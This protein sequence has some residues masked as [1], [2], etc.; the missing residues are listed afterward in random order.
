MC[1]VF[2]EIMGEIHADPGRGKRPCWVQG[3]MGDQS[4]SMLTQGS[5]DTRDFDDGILPGPP[6][7]S[8]PVAPARLY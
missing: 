1:A 6:P 2:K 3:M 4:K 7:P 8:S 5:Y